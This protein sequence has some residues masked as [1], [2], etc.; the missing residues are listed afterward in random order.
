MKTQKLFL[1]V[2]LIIV[3]M[4]TVACGGAGGSPTAAPESAGGTP[5][6]TVEA[7]FTAVFTAEDPDLAGMICSAAAAQADEMVAGLSG[8]KDA[9]AS[10]GAT[11]DISGLT[12]TK[13][14]EEG[15]TATVEVA[16]TMKVSVGGVDQEQ[17]FPAA[18]VP[19][20]REDGA[21]KVCA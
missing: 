10:T 6:E 19:V 2:A 4:V 12:Y 20:R 18:P 21:W 3:A 13:T 11:L 14:A 7:F 9:L 16:G 17:E 1:L 8:M 5:E 15:D